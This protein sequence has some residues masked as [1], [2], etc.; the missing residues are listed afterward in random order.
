M[1]CIWH[2]TAWARHSTSAI[3]PLVHSPLV[4]GVIRL[5]ASG[6]ITS[7]HTR[8]TYSYERWR[9]SFHPCISLSLSLTLPLGL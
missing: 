2:D 6:K 1:T 9:N 5:L 4:V 3:R 8:H 7:R